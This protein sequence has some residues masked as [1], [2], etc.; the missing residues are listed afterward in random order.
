MDKT[1]RLSV[2]LPE[3]LFHE[4]RDGLGHG[5]LRALVVNLLKEAA[6]MKKK[7]PL[8]VSL[9]AAGVPLRRLVK[10]DWNADA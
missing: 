9:L 7:N 6:Q 4:I 8:A 2:D 1:Q 5:Q 10:E 3:K